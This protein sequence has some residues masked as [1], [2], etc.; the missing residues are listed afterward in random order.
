M[1]SRIHR[2][3]GKDDFQRVF[4]KGE[5]AATPF[6]TVRWRE[7][8]LSVPRFGFVVA[9]KISK[10]ATERN[11][12]KRRL[13]ECVRKNIVLCTSPVDVVIVVKQSAL[14]AKSALLEPEIVRTL[15]YIQRRHTASRRDNKK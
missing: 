11:T 2:L 12:I 1:L 5:R 10:K 8:A 7:N 14:G 6:Y 15:S 4:L 3:S 9:N 13:R